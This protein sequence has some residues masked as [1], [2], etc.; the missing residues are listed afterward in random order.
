MNM[1]NKIINLLLCTAVSLNVVEAIPPAPSYITDLYQAVCIQAEANL[2]CRVKSLVENNEFNAAKLAEY[3]A[4]LNGRAAGVPKPSDLYAQAMAIADVVDNSAAAALLKKRYENCLAT[5][6]Y[7]EQFGLDSYY[8]VA[9]QEWNA[10]GWLLIAGGSVVLGT[11]AC[12][13]L[14]KKLCRMKAMVLQRRWKS[15]KTWPQDD[16]PKSSSRKRSFSME[17][18]SFKVEDVSDED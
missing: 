5:E 4:I 11:I 6:R 2:I 10:L 18:R 9:K 17:N 14:V 13:V 1:K 16:A 8:S 3:Q 12:V 15:Q 7:N